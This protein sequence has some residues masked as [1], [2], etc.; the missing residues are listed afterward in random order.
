[1]DA[2]ARLRRR[3]LARLP[4]LLEQLWRPSVDSNQ[5]AVVLRRCDLHRRSVDVGH[6]GRWDL[7]RGLTWPAASCASGA[8]GHDL[9]HRRDAGLR[10]DGTQH[11][12]RYVEEHTRH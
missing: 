2:A 10:Q 11:R 8:D 9:L 7:A 3:L 5:L 1:M 6:D 12:D 4:R